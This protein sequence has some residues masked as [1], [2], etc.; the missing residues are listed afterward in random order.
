M[1]SETA[2]REPGVRNGPVGHVQTMTVSE[3][4]FALAGFFHGNR[5]AGDDYS[6]EFASLFDRLTGSLSLT[7]E[8]NDPLLNGRLATSDDLPIG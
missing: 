3:S 2:A 5:L 1:T 8:G 7:D 4:V 6:H